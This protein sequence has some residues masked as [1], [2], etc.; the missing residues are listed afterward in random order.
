M[1]G[2]F[3]DL[4]RGKVEVTEIPTSISILKYKKWLNQQIEKKTITSYRNFSTEFDVRFTLNGVK[5]ADEYSLNLLRKK[6]LTNMVFLVDGQPRKFATIDS[7]LSQWFKER[8]PHYKRRKDALLQQIAAQI[9]KE[10]TKLKLILL[11][12][13]IDGKPPKINIQKLTKDEIVAAMANEGIPEKKVLNAKMVGLSADSADKLREKIAALNASYGELAD[14][15]IER[16][17][18]RDLDELEGALKKREVEFEKALKA[19]KE[20]MARQTSRKAQ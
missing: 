12:C 1:K 18:L 9:E 6:S 15:P 20:K 10:K 8:L 4:G 19:Q 14:T 11:T 7:Y 13:S 3:K 2:V 5:N 16:L 17:Y